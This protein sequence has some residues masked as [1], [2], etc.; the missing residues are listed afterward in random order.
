[1][2]RVL[3]VDDEPL[4]RDLLRRVLYKDH[5]VVEAGSGEEARTIVERGGIDLVLCDHVMPGMS[6][7]E[8]AREVR[9]ISPGT[10]SLLLT[11]YEGSA[12]VEAA[13]ADGI[14]FAVLA[15][16]WVVAALKVEVARALAA[17][18]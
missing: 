2:P 11:G 3:I 4:N 1:M 18:K 17:K 10:V 8:L 13:R 14:I 7:C 15:K 5:E 12:E 6:G 9:K 16:P